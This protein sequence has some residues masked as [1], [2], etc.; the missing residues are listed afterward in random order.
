MITI[1]GA[2]L[3]GLCCARELARAG[4][5]VT[6]LEAGA[7]PGGRVRS[8]VV[9]GYVVDRGFQVLFTAYPTLRA[10]LDLDGAGGERLRL[11]RFAPAARVGRARGAG[12]VG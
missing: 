9:D 3:A 7:E 5:A 8:R 6:V 11:R 12:L 2:G 4:R 10:A 1:V